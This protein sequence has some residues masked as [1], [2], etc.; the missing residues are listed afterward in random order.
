MGL[1]VYV[2][3]AEA[4][5]ELGDA[6]EL[7]NGEEEGSTPLS[8]LQVGEVTARSLSPLPV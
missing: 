6:E 3:I 5:E 2:A 4:L 1:P 7:L 8:I